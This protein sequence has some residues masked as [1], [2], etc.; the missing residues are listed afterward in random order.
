[1][2]PAGTGAAKK[3]HMNP[4][5][6]LQCG[7]MLRYDTVDANGIYHAFAMIVVA[8][9][10]SDFSQTPYMTFRYTPSYPTFYSNN[11]T[12]HGNGNGTADYQTYNTT[13]NAPQSGEEVKV[14]IAGDKIWTFHGLAGP[15]SFWRMKFEIK[16]S[17]IEM[18]VSYSINSGK[19]LNFYVPAINQNMRWVGHSCNGFSAGVDTEAF[20]G[21]DPLWNDLL[22]RHAQEPIHLLVGGGDQIYCDSIAREPEITPWID[23]TDLNKKM[24]TPLTDEIRFAVDRFLFNHYTT[25]FRS[26]AFGRAIATIPMANMMD[27]HDLIDGFG[28]YPDDLQT[29]PVFSH[30]GSR[31]IFFYHLFQLFIVNEVDGTDASRPHPNQ[32]IIVGGP[33][34]YVPFDNHSFLI[35]LGPTVRMLLL[36][37]RTERRL[38]QIVS[39]YTYEKVFSQL[40]QLPSQVQHLVVLLGVPI[41]YPRMVMIEGLLTSKY[42]PITML[43]RKG[44]PGFSGLINKF[45]KDAELGDDLNDHWTA[46]PHK[47]ERN[48]LVLEFQ[49]LAVSNRLRITYLSGDVHLAAVGYFFDKHKIKPELDP[50]YA[51]NIISSAIVNTPPP[52][53]LVG[54]QGKLNKKVHKTLHHENTDETMMDVFKTDTDG[55]TLKN[56]YFMGRRNY[57]IAHTDPQGDLCFGIMVEKQQGVGETKEYGVVIPPPRWI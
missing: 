9:A 13:A 45:N 8:D 40:R 30:V 48:W 31:G 51:V 53:A 57:C 24:Q 12:W 44:V 26:G 14:T 41:A 15:N 38:D 6:Q 11:A 19:E 50:K 29:S 21:P 55:K 3:Y 4:H 56:P 43:G 7:P 32:S 5:L 23:E 28:S 54:L 27:D 47:P 20:N 35:W 37:C 39:K 49:K 52:P 10:G 34:P 2:P 42:N 33:G 46:T 1:M 36:D 17:D 25:W 22:K 16:L 18:K